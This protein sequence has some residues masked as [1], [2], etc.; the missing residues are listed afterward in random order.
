MRLDDQG[1]LAFDTV[2]VRVVDFVTLRAM[3]DTIVCIGDTLR[4]R[5]DTDG[6]RF[7]W[8]NPSTLNNPTLLTP[9]ARPVSDPTVYTITA[10]IGPRC[11]ATDDVVVDLTPYS[12]VNAGVIPPSATT[13]WHN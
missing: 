5:A 8:D 13:P 7:L 3:A 4:L 10:R 6:L 9:T 11:F 2:R 1:C 12:T